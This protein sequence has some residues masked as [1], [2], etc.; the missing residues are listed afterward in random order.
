MGSGKLLKYLKPKAWKTMSADE[1]EE[2]AR[3]DAK[4]DRSVRELMIAIGFAIGFAWEQCFDKSVDS[5]AEV[6]KDVPKIGK[7]NIINPT[8]TKMFL[9]IFCC[10]L[11]VPAW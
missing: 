4:T 3:F 7:L 6:T 2:A 9:A 5:I 10:A 11:L 1:K 8:S